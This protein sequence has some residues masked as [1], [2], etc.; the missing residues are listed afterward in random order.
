MLSKRFWVAWPSAPALWGF[1]QPLHFC[2][3]PPPH[4]EAARCS[5]RWPRG[6][7]A[8]PIHPA[9]TAQLGEADKRPDEMW[10]EQHTSVPG[11][12]GNRGVELRAGKQ[13]LTSACCFQ[14]FRGGVKGGGG[15]GDRKSRN[16]VFQARFVGIPGLSA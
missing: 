9:F 14:F 7:K 1:S 10:C 11:C 15:V 13:P 16:G 4:L 5:A 3:A 6:K 12:H 2:P 8:H